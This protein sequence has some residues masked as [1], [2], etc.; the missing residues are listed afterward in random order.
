VL[1]GKASNLGGLTDG[2]G[3]N[4][5]MDGGGVTG[6]VG[7]FPIGYP[8]G[9]PGN[10]GTA[11]VVHNFGGSGGGANGGSGIVIIRYPD[12]F[13]PATSATVSPTV[14]GGYRIYRFTANGSITF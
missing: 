7:G 14:T 4:R 1:G 10:V 12:T 6:G 8:A 5:G 9:T 11:A 3:F 2:A 13:L